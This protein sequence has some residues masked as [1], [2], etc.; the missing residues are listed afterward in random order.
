MR[1][2][3]GAVMYVEGACVLLLLAVADRWNRVP[4]HTLSLPAAAAAGD[5]SSLSASGDRQTTVQTANQWY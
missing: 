5:C 1:P 4:L 3:S 2:S